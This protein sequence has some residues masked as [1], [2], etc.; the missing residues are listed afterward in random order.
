MAEARAW[1]RMKG[2][3]HQ[4]FEAFT[5][6][7]TQGPDRSTARVAQQLGKSK[8]LMDRWSSK[9]SW[10]MR[11]TSYEEHFALRMLDETEDE[12]AALMREHAGFASEV[13]RRARARLEFAAAEM[14]E[15]TGDPDQDMLNMIQLAKQ[16]KLMTIDQALRAGD[17][18][19]KVARLAVG[20][21]GKYTP[22]GAGTT[23]LSNLDDA[24]LDQLESILDKAKGG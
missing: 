5:C 2:E 13:L 23:D 12:R 20:L 16:G 10:V 22:Q 24:D 14:P 17:L 4:A 15:P 11:V 7:L 6:Y 1:F 19:V 18:A 8:T 9:W 21:D 3:S